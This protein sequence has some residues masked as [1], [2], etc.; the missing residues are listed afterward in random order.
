MIVSRSSRTLWGW[1]QGTGLGGWWEARWEESAV[2]SA[3]LRLRKFLQR[4]GGR[5]GRQGAAGEG[6]T[7]VTEAAS[8]ERPEIRGQSAQEGEKAQRPSGP[9]TPQLR[10]KDSPGRVHGLLGGD[11]PASL[12]QGPRPQPEACSLAPALLPRS[13]PSRPARPPQASAPLQPRVETWP[14]LLMP[15][16]GLLRG[17]GRCSSP[18][19]SVGPS[20]WS[21]TSSLRPGRHPL[22]VRA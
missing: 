16:T 13:W 14:C 12:A 10:L 17:C 2:L 6:G 9:H 19:G 5:P 22:V 3:T 1:A 15:L 11:G 20:A 21:P 18:Q 7:W 8:P 4:V